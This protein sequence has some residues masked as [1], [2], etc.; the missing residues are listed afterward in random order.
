[1]NRPLSSFSALSRAAPSK[2]M[3]KRAG[4]EPPWP[5]EFEDEV[6]R[7][8]RR[9]IATAYWVVGLG[10]GVFLIWAFF[11]PLDEGV[12]SPGTVVIET[13]R[14]VVQHQQG[15]LV[16]QV[17]VKEGQWVEQGELL[18]QLDDSAAMANLQSARQTRASLNENRLAQRAVL[19][20]LEQVEQ[21][22]KSQQQ[23][24]E[25]ELLGLRQVVSE[26]YAP[27]SQLYQLERTLSDL[28]SSVA[29]LL[30]N[31]QKARQAILDLD[32][33]L[34]AADE[35]LRAAQT[36]F[37]RLG[38][39]A[40]VS[41]QVVGLTIASVGAVVQPAER[42]MEIV[43][44]N[45]LLLIEARVPPQYIDRIREGGAADVRFSAFANSPQLVAP[46][47]LQSVS[48]DALLDAASQ[49][50]HYLARVQL[51]EEGINQLE[52]R[53]LH[54][55]MPVEVVLKTGSRTLLEYLLHPLTKRLAASMKEE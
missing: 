39:L 13:K 45:E 21:Y 27:A 37:S 52:G 2:V 38:I 42:I 55:G 12:P 49:Q 54:P 19:K 43:P 15:G 47:I 20:G 26:G 40:P 30:A 48:A 14:K 17:L 9:S 8:L 16:A 22:R 35:R 25:K 18:L 6:R 50:Q 1:M 51:T 11:V 32:H 53:A 44:V 7:Y 46:G 41:G 33:Q 5:E 31:Q 29:D 36:D 10:L 4:Q 23:L 3:A 24:L 34:L 28:Q